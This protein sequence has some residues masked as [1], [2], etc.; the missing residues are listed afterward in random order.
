MLMYIVLFTA[1]LLDP[2]LKREEAGEVPASMRR[3]FVSSCGERSCV[4]G[5]TPI[6]RRSSLLVIV[7]G[8]SQGVLDG[9]ITAADAFDAIDYALEPCTAGM[10]R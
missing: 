10:T 5:S 2:V 1:S 4:P 7:I 8:L 3:V 9:Q 6:R